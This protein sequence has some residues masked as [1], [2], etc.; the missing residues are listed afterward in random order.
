M[1]FLGLDVRA[2]NNVHFPVHLS[3]IPFLQ[4]VNNIFNFTPGPLRALELTTYYE[5]SYLE[6]INGL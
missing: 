1:V 2:C 5:I 3:S 4:Q 6:N